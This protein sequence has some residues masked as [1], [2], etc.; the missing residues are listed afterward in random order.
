MAAINRR[1]RFGV[2]AV[3]GA[4]V[5]VAGCSHFSAMHWPWGH[6]AQSPPTAVNELVETDPSGN[7]ASYPQYWKRNTLLVDL[8]GVAAEGEP[9]IDAACRNGLASAA[10]I[11]GDARINRRPR[12][13]RRATHDPSCRPRGPPAGR[14]RARA[15]RLRRDDRADH[16]ALECALT[17]LQGSQT[18]GASPSRSSAASAP[19]HTQPLSSPTTPCA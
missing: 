6:K 5:L 16:C 15:G 11:S 17:R 4:A 8:H 9:R 1:N 19:P 18:G 14:S 10:G 12:S 2:A 7:A 13:A 3:M